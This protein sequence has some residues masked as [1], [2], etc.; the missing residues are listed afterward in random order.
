MSYPWIMTKELQQRRPTGHWVQTERAAHEAWASL[1]GRKPKAAELMHH[2]VAR[3]GHQNAVVV[4]QKVLG[5]IMNC[6]VDTVQ[7]ALKV[8]EAERWI[9]IVR[10]GKG[11]EAAYVINDRVAWGQARDQ[12]RLSMFS[13]TVIADVEDQDPLSLSTDPLQRIPSL[14]PGETA[15]PHGPG[16][17]PPSQPILEGMEPSLVRDPRTLDWVN[18]QADKE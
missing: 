13:A 6:S 9:Q 4:P 16:D 7:R 15:I 2:L 8:L 17:T 1:I 10:I 14:F 18:G 3:M 5:K 12:L 11:K